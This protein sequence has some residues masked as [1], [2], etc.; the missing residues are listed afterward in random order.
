MISICH[1]CGVQVDTLRSPARIV[2]SRVV[3]YCARCGANP[4]AALAQAWRAATEDRLAGESYAHDEDDAYDDDPIG[5]IARFTRPRKVPTLVATG[6]IAAGMLLWTMF[7]PSDPKRPLLNRLSS[8]AEAATALPGPRPVSGEHARQLPGLLELSG[9]VHPL[10]GGE[11]LLPMEPIRRF[12]ADREGLGK[13]RGCGHGH[14]GVDIGQRVGAPVVAVADGVIAKV[15]RYDNFNGGL[16]VRVDHAD[17]TST[18]YFHLNAIRADLKPG[19]SVQAGEVIAELGRSGILNSPAHLHFAL[20]LRQG[21]TDHYVDPEPY[22]R[23]AVLIAAPTAGD[24]THMLGNEGPS[25]ARLAADRDAERAG[26]SAS[27]ETPG[28]S[29]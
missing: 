23:N 21:E 4:E 14:C 20:A 29:D 8:H 25:I 26:A 15:V 16:Y 5:R 6:A 28:I 18:F 22:L 27:V 7:A 13:A 9:M 12:G 1:A 11:L 2:A 17:D 10:P 3:S 19:V 24:L